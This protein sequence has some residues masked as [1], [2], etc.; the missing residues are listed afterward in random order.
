[1]YKR[2]IWSSGRTRSFRAM[3]RCVN[4]KYVCFLIPCYFLS[5]LL[6]FGTLDNYSYHLFCRNIAYH[7]LVL[8]GQSR[9][10]VILIPTGPNGHRMDPYESATAAPSKG[11]LQSSSPW[12]FSPQRHTR[13][14]EIRCLNHFADVSVSRHRQQTL[15]AGR[16]RCVT[17]SFTKILVQRPS[18]GSPMFLPALSVEGLWED[19]GFARFRST[20]DAPKYGRAGD[21]DPILESALVLPN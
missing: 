13:I 10:S 9:I 12:E 6:T 14:R 11:L 20:I 8:I 7:Y 4:G 5:G 2:T 1:M 16:F 19:F 3:L 21:T 18:Q 17:I 15:L